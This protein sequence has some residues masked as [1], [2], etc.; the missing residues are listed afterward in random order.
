VVVLDLVDGTGDWRAHDVEASNRGTGSDLPALPGAYAL[1]IEFDRAAVLPPR[2]GVGSLPPGRY[3]YLG[4][5]RGPGGIRARLARHL[6][7]SSKRHWH[8]DWLTEAARDLSALA[9]PGGDECDLVR[10][11]LEM[12]GLTVPVSGFGSSDC[13]RCPAH[14]LA[15]DDAVGMETLAARVTVEPEADDRRAT[16]RPAWRERSIEQRSPEA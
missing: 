5:A 13:R 2:L 1:L 12:P 14:L 16:C 11:M 4:S 10:R 8:V 3:I 7:G 9:V 15:L 6:R